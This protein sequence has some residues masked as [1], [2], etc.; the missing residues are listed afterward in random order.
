MGV[1]PNG[2]TDDFL[3][4]E[5]FK[6]TFIPGARA[7]TETLGEPIL[8]LFDG[9]GSHIA[10]DLLTLAFENKDIHLICL[11]PHTTHKLQ[12]LDVGIF[13]P[14][15]TAWGKR[16]REVI[17]ET[18]QGI[19]RSDIVKEYMSVRSQTFTSELIQKA[20]ER[21]GLNPINKDIFT[22]TDFAPSVSTSTIPHMP[23]SYP[24]SSNLPFHHDS[25]STSGQ[26]SEVTDTA[27]PPSDFDSEPEPHGADD[28]SGMGANEEPKEAETVTADKD[29]N[30]R[31]E[32]MQM[33]V[34]DSA[35]T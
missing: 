10:D 3:C 15:Q 16:C 18:G 32:G 6:K 9:H 24:D 1:S 19:P 35:F 34:C 2:W 8:L 30:G 21:C 13:G 26:Q 27:H 31:V 28:D 25:V 12:P 23:S 7:R 33:M 17:K 11:P 22:E 29:D 14:L 20:F 5:W 4:Y